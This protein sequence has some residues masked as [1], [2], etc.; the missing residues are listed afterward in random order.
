M[1]AVLE[2]ENLKTEFHLRSANVVAVD[3][4]SF[5]VEEGECVGLVGESGCGKTTTGLSVMKLL[6]NVGHVTGGS[7]RLLGRDLAPLN[8]R[9]M[10]KVRGND[11]G[12]IFQDPLT[13]LNPTM[14]IGR[15]IA[16]SVRLHR[17]AS[18][19]EARAAPWRCCRWSRCPDPV[20]ASTPT[21]T[22]C[23]V[24]CASGS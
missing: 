8:E 13:S 16:E 18:K 7:I 11:V 6:P 19:A 12:M 2:V 5:H 14:T 22:S 10:C 24:A 4:V 21:P 23:R 17:G 3:D 1:S 15:Q 9:E 20:N